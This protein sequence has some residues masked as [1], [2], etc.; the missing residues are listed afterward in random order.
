MLSRTWTV[1]CPPCGHA[2]VVRFLDETKRNACGGG[3]G[4]EGADAWAF[5]VP[6]T[7]VRRVACFDAFVCLESYVGFGIGRVEGAEFGDFFAALSFLL[8]GEATVVFRR[9]RQSH[10]VYM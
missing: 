10:L 9:P 4:G 5:T 2:T 1:S 6:G 8:A 7:G 3:A